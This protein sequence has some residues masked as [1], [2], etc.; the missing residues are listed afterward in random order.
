MLFIFGQW[1]D[2]LWSRLVTSCGAQ[3][4]PLDPSSCVFCTGSTELVVMDLTS[5]ETKQYPAVPT[6]QEEGEEA[7]GVT[8]GVERRTAQKTR[9]ICVFSR[10]GR[11][12]YCLQ[13]RTLV[14][15]DSASMEVLV[16]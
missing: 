2:G 5:G 3:L 6:S 9:G 11:W 7:A 1:M 14:K 15:R 8:T 16:K 12:L 10:D 4:F 13:G